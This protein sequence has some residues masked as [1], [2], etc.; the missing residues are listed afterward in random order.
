MRNWSF[1][2]AQVAIEQLALDGP[3]REVAEYWLSL[4][5]GNAPPQGCGFSLSQLGAN[6]P[7]AALLELGAGDS[8]VCR[9][10]GRYFAILLGKDPVGENLLDGAT[11]YE[12]E[13]RLRRARAM[14][15]GAIMWGER[16]FASDSGNARVAEIYLPF[17][18]T[19]ADGQRYFLSHSNWRANG[20]IFAYGITDGSLAASL[21]ILSIAADDG[22][23]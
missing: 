10:A 22:S 12:R 9:D 23:D 16:A 21:R 19:G 7:A 8:I 20:K 11:P 1:R 4:W 5:N 6:A 2:S 13:E 18:G 14:V 17:G 3:N 15:D